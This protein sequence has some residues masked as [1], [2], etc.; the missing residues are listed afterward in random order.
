MEKI[1]ILFYTDAF[2]TDAPDPDLKTWGLSELKNL[3]KYKTRG[4]VEFEFNLV[5]RH[6]PL[7]QL[8]PKFLC[9]Y[10]EV[11]IFG[12]LPWQGLPF[13]LFD[14]EVQALKEWMD[15]GGGLFITGDHSIPKDGCE[16]DHAKF[17]NLGRSLG[18]RIKRAKELRVWQGPPTV[19][20][21]DNANTQDGNVSDLDDPKLDKDDIAQTLVDFPDPPHR[22]FWWK[23]ET[24]G[25]VIPVQ[26]FPDHGHEGALAFPD[27]TG[28]D[29]PSGSPAPVVA[30][31]GRD[32]RFPVKPVIYPLVLAYDGDPVNVG[33]IVA[34][35][36]FHHY[37]NLNLGRLVRRLANGYPEPDSD[38]DQIAQFFGNLALWLVPRKIRDK[39]KWEVL[40]RIVDH[41][42]VFEAQGSGVAYLG[43]VARLSRDLEVE[44]QDFYR[45]LAPSEFEAPQTLLDEL[46]NLLILGE[47]SF[48]KLNIEDQEFVYGT[49]L[50]VYHQLTWGTL[51]FGVSLDER[52]PA[53]QLALSQGLQLVSEQVPELGERVAFARAALDELASS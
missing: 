7:R 32:K 51:P 31:K 37:F 21:D 45:V 17:L 9:Q 13:E 39:M 38:L 16:E 23:V 43:K 26:K 48:A 49:I 10:D 50:T 44:F 24:G 42:E 4:L 6:L 28:P 2:I 36:S 11:W 33:R 22:L 25:K 19:C 35:S 30:A 52:L 47:N 5:L 41:P 20:T 3:I 15:Q 34:D 1:R 27:L 18:R 46:L 40:R 29:W 53:L 14:T 8:E 12:V